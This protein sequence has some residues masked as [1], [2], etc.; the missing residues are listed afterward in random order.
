MDPSLRTARAVRLLA[1]F[2]VTLTVSGPISAQQAREEMPDLA[3]MEHQL[4]EAFQAA[5][6]ISD[7]EPLNL[8]QAWGAVILDAM[9]LER[10]RALAEAGEGEEPAMPDPAAV[11]ETILARWQHARPTAGGPDLFRALQIEDP[12]RQRAA[13]VALLDRY[14]Q[15]HVIVWQAAFQLRNAGE[16]TRAREVLESFAAQNPDRSIAYRFLAQDASDN[17]TRLAEVLERWA[18][19]VPGDPSL[20]E[21]WMSSTLVRQEPEATERL[22]REF[23]D[24][25]LP[26]D[27]EV[28]RACQQVLERGAPAFADPA[29]VCIARI[30]GDPDVPPQVAEPAITSLVGMAAADGDW[31]AFL[32]A[33][34]ALQPERRVQALVSA[35]W[36]V[37][38]PSRC[39]E[40]IDLL[41]VASEALG[42]EDT[43]AYGS[44]TSVLQSCS[45][46]PAAEELFRTL[47]RSAPP[48][49][50]LDVVS[51]WLSRVNGV[52]R[53][54]LPP[55]T[56]ELLEGRLQRNPDS[57][58]LLAA[59]DVAYQVAGERDKRIDLLLRWQK[60]TSSRFD[61]SQTI[62]LA[63]GLVARDQPQPAVEVLERQLEHGGEA[64]VV[65]ALWQLYLQTDGLERAERLA[66]DMI[67]SG[68]GWR[69]R[70]GHLLA[71]RC[72]LVREDAGAAEEQYWKALEGDAASEAVAVELLAS[73]RWRGDEPRLE[74]TAR[75][76]CVETGLGR[77]ASG[78]AACTAKLLTRIGS[79]D[80]AAGVL[81]AE[82]SELPDDLEALRAL[83]STARTA[84]D[85]DLAARAQRRILELDPRSEA[86]WTGLGQLLME[87]GEAAELAALLERSRAVFSPPPVGLYRSTGQALIAAGEPRQAIDLLSEARGTLPA[88]EGGE[89]S[90]G[91]LD[92]DLRTAYEALGRDLVAPAAAPGPPPRPSFASAEPPA[93]AAT[94]SGPELLR[95]AED[96]QSG[97]AGHYDPVRAREL[98]V[99]AAVVG[100][101]QAAFRLALLQHLSPAEIPPGEPAGPELLQRA[102]PTVREQAE[103][104]DAYS[105]Y[106]VG[107]A[108]LVGLG[109]PADLAAARQWLERSAGQG[110]SWAWHN[111]A[112]MQETGRG[113]P[114]PDPQAAVA[115]Y[116]KASEAGNA[117]SAIDLA[118]LTLTPGGSGPLCEEGLRWLERSARSGNA[119]AAS[120]LGKLLFYGQGECVAW[121][122]EAARPWLE[123]AS[124]T[125]QPGGDYDLG[126]ALV[127]TGGNGTA[128]ERGISLLEGEAAR[129]DA[130][131][132]ETLAFLYATGI[133]V[134][135]DVARSRRLQVEAARLG[136]DGFGRM[137]QALAGSDVFRDL[138]ERGEARLEALV[139]RSDPAAAALLA[140]LH[141]V[142]I[143]PAGRLADPE[144][145]VALARQGA[146]GGEALA[147]RVLAD[148][149]LAGDGVEKDEEEGHRWRRRC[150]EAGDGFCMMF[151]GN[152]LMK[153]EGY[154]R[155]V[156]GGL[157]WLR[158]SAEAG[159]WWATADLGH[160]Y[161]EGWYGIPRDPDEAADWMR[162]LAAL[163]D[164]EATG[165]LAYHGY[166]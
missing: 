60:T 8:L 29:R 71:A 4:E 110:E 36:K 159:N 35:A 109:G 77:E 88:T 68:Q 61:G 76:I 112:W 99:R 25:T 37:P 166:R 104:G 75:R 115:S 95:A 151:Y 19:A 3:T 83:A 145:M 21:A 129:P 7:D 131:S 102:A 164:P 162:R 142:G 38:R 139:A 156:A 86:S 119:R 48:N 160:L 128:R 23:F 92:H 135:R 17:Q 122:A 163:G 11:A 155:D 144:R 138:I 143:A 45:E 59:L 121:G 13:V 134:D 165:W 80:L 133:G 108:A 15:D 114:R 49:G 40:A 2:L 100:D 161:D 42:G 9:I 43:G 148:A 33:L 20:V 157:A 89:W 130:L 152:G 154:E 85:L 81:T 10:R 146:A 67:A 69:A 46:H 117:V 97:R 55:G 123:A 39:S 93:V 96:L 82:G 105:Q 63:E 44:I 30:A 106:L 12:E 70:A 51:R 65:D 107:T 27:F 140:R 31:T 118:R 16:G 90:R 34:D 103:K 22:L 141:S 78:T 153:G 56:T 62:A 47:L 53:G 1:S 18:R 73:I 64:E 66:A 24:R 126:L 72:A 57:P 150:A 84:G 6:E 127:L 58:E 149:Y 120:R 137:R 74:P 26:S 136:S 14:P 147:M 87:R 158:R 79:S 94:A 124:A 116:R 132:V 91:W 101:P 52:W 111:L 32:A 5:L 41:T 28:L 98:L 54:E 50:A 125:H 113:Y